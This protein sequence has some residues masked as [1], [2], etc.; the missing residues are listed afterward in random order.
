MSSPCPECGGEGRVIS[1]PCKECKGQGRV[2]EK[3]RVKVHIPAGVDTGMRLKMSGYGDAGEG[4]G[5]P[6]DLYVFINVEPH[7]IFARQ[8]DDI[9]LDLPVGFGEA[10]LGTK[11]EIPT[12]FGRCNLTIPEGTQSGKNFRIRGEGFPNVH[13]RG[14]GDLLVRVVVE[15]PTHLTAKQKEMLKTF[16]ETE[17]VDNL[18]HKKS[19][20]EKIKELFPGKG[21]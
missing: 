21:K 14:K 19:F 8:G 5:P 2:K 4:G 12:L 7:P 16:G 18:P 20:L 17:G 9:L 3:D 6:G 10:A 13:G 1:D 11:K 15:T